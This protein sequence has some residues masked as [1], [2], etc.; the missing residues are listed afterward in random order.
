[1]GDR[2]KGKVVTVTGAGSIGPVWGLERL[3]RFSMPGRELE[4]W[5][6]I[7]ILRQPKK[8]SI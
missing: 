3:Q 6:L 7:I 5:W 8:P 2:V 4:S 1:M